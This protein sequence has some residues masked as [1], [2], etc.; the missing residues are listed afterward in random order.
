MLT[1][2]GLGAAPPGTIYRA[3]TVAPGS[4]TPVPAASF[5]GSTPVVPLATR[6]AKGARVAVTL[7]PAAGGDRPSRPLRL[8]A[9]RD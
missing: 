1:L 2:D 4:A 7:E 6:V 5:D 8:V 9:V 3:W